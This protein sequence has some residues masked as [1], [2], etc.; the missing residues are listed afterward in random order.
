[1]SSTEGKVS[2]ASPE[3]SFNFMRWFSSSSRLLPVRSVKYPFLHF[4][5]RSWQ[6]GKAAVAWEAGKDLSI[7][8]IEVAP[9]KAHEVRIEIYYTGVCHT[10]TSQPSN[11]RLTLEL[12]VSADAYT[13]SGK[14]PEGAFPIVL[15]HEGAGVV[16]SVGE[17][18]TSVKKGDYVV[19]L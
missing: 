7:E 12:I 9:P 11:W 16:E 19:A 4:E 2:K 5:Q 18:V 14:D 13:L 10:G 15:G 1:M 17:G 6:I 8:T 3:R